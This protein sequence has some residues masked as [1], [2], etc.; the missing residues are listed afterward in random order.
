MKIEP[1]LQGTLNIVFTE[2]IKEKELETHF[3]HIDPIKKI[4]HIDI[5]DRTE[6]AIEVRNKFSRKCFLRQC[7]RESDMNAREKQL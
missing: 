3:Q 6:K 4:Q 5:A 1:S 2:L 7:S